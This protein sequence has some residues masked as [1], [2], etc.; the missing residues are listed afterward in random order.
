MWGDQIPQPS[1]TPRSK[2]MTYLFKCRHTYV[3]Q[4]D[5]FS[6]AIRLNRFLRFRSF[7]Q[8]APPIVQ[9]APPNDLPDLYCFSTC[10]GNKLPA[11]HLLKVCK[12]ILA[13]R[14][15]AVYESANYQHPVYRP[16][17]VLG[18]C[19]GKCLPTSA[20]K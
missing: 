6:R 19:L 12:V 5:V 9:S 4:S 2:S 17:V 20:R 14:T 3:C 18:I 7:V 8:S 11:L 1:P 16:E 15:S 13:L 10:S